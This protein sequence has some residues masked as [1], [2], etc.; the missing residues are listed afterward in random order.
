LPP[1]VQYIVNA[2]PPATQYAVSETPTT[3][4]WCDPTW[5]NCGLAWGPAFYPANVFVLRAPS[6]R[7]F[8][9]MPGGHHGSV[10]PPMR[11]FDGF[12]RG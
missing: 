10:H 11:P 1:V 2:A 12:R 6:F 8:Q 5:L 3:S 4:S 7:H 9:S